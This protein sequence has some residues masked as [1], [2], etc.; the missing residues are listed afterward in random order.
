MDLVWGPDFERM[1]QQ[2]KYD[3]YQESELFENRNSMRLPPMHS[4]PQERVLDSSGTFPVAL[5]REYL[6]TGRERYDIYCGVCHGL[7]GDGESPVAQNMQLRTPPSLHQ[8]YIVDL[9][10]AQI[11]SAIVEGYGVMPAYEMQL[12]FEEQWAVVAYVRAL[13]MSRGVSIVEIPS[14]VREELESIPQEAQGE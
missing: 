14:D 1:I 11:H 2:E 4:I 8:G 3:P 7:L 5:T 12:S 9:S 13:Q 6:Q 10:D